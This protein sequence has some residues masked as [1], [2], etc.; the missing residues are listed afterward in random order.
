MNGNLSTSVK[1]FEETIA[2]KMIIETQQ[3]DG[4]TFEF[5]H[6]A[7]SLLLLFIDK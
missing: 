3:I 5:G 2:H 4:R 1:Y 6:G 7:S